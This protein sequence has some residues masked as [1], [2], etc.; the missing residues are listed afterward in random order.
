[1]E[2]ITDPSDWRRT[3]QPGCPTIGIESGDYELIVRLE[4]VPS[5]EVLAESG[6]EAIRIMVAATVTVT[7]T[8]P[9][10]PTA[11]LA[12]VVVLP[13]AVDTP[14]ATAT[15]T[16]MA[17]PT[18]ATT[19]ESTTPTPEPTEPRLPAVRVTA[20][21]ANIRWG[22]SVAFS[23][24]GGLRH[25]TEVQVLASTDEFG[26]WYLIELADGRTGWIAASVSSQL[27]KAL[28]IALVAG[29]YSG[30]AIKYTN[31]L[32][33]T[34][35][36]IRATP[37]RSCVPRL[38]RLCARYADADTDSAD[39]DYIYRF[40][41]VTRCLHYEEPVFISHCYYGRFNVRCIVPGTNDFCHATYVRVDP[42]YAGSTNHQ[43]RPATAF[44][45]IASRTLT[46]LNNGTI[47]LPVCW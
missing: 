47:S 2:T 26:Y 27:L 45:V 6:V 20:A 31:F 17:T 32:P 12:P 15:S 41:T 44:P 22:P 42:Q 13:T 43:E 29:L 18:E 37:R 25:G 35:P 9:V 8:M 10:T 30:I 21:S 34:L 24:L 11:S 39:I 7:A 5:G 16:P 33:P 1:M 23:I 46:I 19:P 3:I 40:I 36:P 38:S 14:T 4:A 28:W